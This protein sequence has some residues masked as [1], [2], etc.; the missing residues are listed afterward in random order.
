[1]GYNFNITR[2]YKFE[3]TDP[4]E[5]NLLST[6]IIGIHHAKHQKTRCEK[7]NCDQKNG[8]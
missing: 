3:L 4:E 7:E 5:C 8:Q 2:V 6:T 1:M